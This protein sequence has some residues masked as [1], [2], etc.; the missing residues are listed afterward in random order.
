MELNGQLYS[1]P[2]SCI[3]WIG[4]SVDPPANLEAVQKRFAVTLLHFYLHNSFPCL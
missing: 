4:G 2:P 3:H 1:L